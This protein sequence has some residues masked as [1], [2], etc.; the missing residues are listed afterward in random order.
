MK[1]N[2]I[3]IDLLYGKIEGAHRFPYYLI[4]H[5]LPDRSFKIKGKYFPICSRC[6]GLYLSAISFYI[7]AMF[8]VIIYN[9]NMIIL[10]ILLAI[11]ILVDGFTQ[12]VGVRESNNKL[13][14]I[15]G[16]CGGLSLAIFAKILKFAMIS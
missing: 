1:I 3:Y 4:C 8:T 13:R 9:S 14:F 15:T 11:P 2:P 5:R 12:L 16:L 7:Y 6:T 10:A